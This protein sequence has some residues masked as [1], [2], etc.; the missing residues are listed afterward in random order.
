MH[1]QYHNSPCPAGV[2]PEDV[3]V[4][5]NALGARANK[6]QVQVLH[7]LYFS[8]EPPDD[9]V[10]PLP[11]LDSPYT[12]SPQYPA[13]PELPQDNTT[14]LLETLKIFYLVFDRTMFTYSLLY[15][16]LL[17]AL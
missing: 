8:L 12:R 2:E 3:V 11:P 7:P 6:V 17:T 15:A 13:D 10:E 5:N 14:W 1:Q 16:V 9:D 4:P